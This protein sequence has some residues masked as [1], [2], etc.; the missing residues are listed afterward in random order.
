M[1]HRKVRNQRKCRDCDG[2]YGAGGWRKSRD[3]PFVGVGS[4]VND[5]D[6][7]SPP[8]SGVITVAAIAS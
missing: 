6:V 3:V 5:L 2:Q 1:A 7:P 8:G 4:C